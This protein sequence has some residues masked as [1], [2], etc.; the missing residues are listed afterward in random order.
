M[1]DARICCGGCGLLSRGLSL[2]PSSPSSDSFDRHQQYE[3]TSTRSPYAPEG[4]DHSLPF[5]HRPPGRLPTVTPTASWPTRRPIAATYSSVHMCP[6]PRPLASPTTL[7]GLEYLYY[8]HAKVFSMPDLLPVPSIHRSVTAVSDETL[9]LRMD[10]LEQRVPADSSTSERPLYEKELRK[11][12]VL[13]QE[14]Q[15]AALRRKLM[16]LYTAKDKG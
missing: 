15:L 10:A 9:R 16:P 5:C 4:P 3:A 8:P 13:R 6:H 11:Q 12:V 14:T 2:C 1:Y 7:A